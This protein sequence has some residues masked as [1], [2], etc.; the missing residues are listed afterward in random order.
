[1]KSLKA[2]NAK[3]K[4]MLAE[5]VLDNEAP[6]VVTREKFWDVGAVVAVRAKTKRSERRTCHC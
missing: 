1:M 2:E 5:V 4:K 6:K 3:L